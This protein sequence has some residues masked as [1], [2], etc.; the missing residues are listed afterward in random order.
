MDILGFCPEC[1]CE[2]IDAIPPRQRLQYPP[3]TVVCADCGYTERR[4]R[5]YLLRLT[6]ELRSQSNNANVT[7]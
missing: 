6:E 4:P 1:R 5:D 7:T 2:T 3:P